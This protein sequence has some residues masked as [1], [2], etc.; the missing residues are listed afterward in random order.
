MSAEHTIVMALANAN[1]A[2]FPPGFVAWL[3]AN[4]HI[5][6]AFVKQA[7]AVIARGYRHYSARTIIEVLR[8]HTALTEKSLGGLKLNDH[9]CPY[10][11]RLFALRYPQHRRFFS[12]RDTNLEKAT[13][14]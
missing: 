6:E 9:S 14:A 11:S 13:E 1:P 4:P 8:H 5:W 3:V 12:F 10:L 7:F 2:T